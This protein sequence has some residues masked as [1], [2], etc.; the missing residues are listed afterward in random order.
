MSRGLSIMAWGVYGVA[1]PRLLNNEVQ[2]QMQ[3]A[4]LEDQRA[5]KIR[6]L[7]SGNLAQGRRRSHDGGIG[8][9][10]IGIIDGRNRP[11]PRCFLTTKLT[12]SMDCS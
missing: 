12:F 10:R 4:D 8:L 6:F 9:I 11:P 7:L 2:V 3:M 5:S 1:G